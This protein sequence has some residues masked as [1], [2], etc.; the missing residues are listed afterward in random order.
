[1]TIP[2][3][4]GLALLLATWATDARAQTAAARNGSDHVVVPQA[5]AYAMN[6]SPAMQITGV[7]VGV[8]RKTLKE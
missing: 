1:M 5:R 8:V 4:I 2:R 7:T 3:I 6:R